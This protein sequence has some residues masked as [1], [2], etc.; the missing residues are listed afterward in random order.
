MTAEN[1]SMSSAGGG[2]SFGRNRFS[3]AEVA[4]LHDGVDPIDVS[5]RSMVSSNAMLHVWIVCYGGNRSRLGGSV[6]SSHKPGF[7]YL[8]TL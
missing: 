2:S 3:D 7:F 4:N 1:S 5:G 8:L 6:A